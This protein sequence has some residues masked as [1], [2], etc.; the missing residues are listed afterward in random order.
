MILIAYGNENGNAF[1][2]GKD[3]TK[4]LD[5]HGAAVSSIDFS[6]NGDLVATGSWDGIARLWRS[7]VNNEPVEF[8]LHDSWIRDV[9][10]SSNSQFLL[11]GGKDRLV[12]R[13]SMQEVK[14]METLLAMKYE[15]F[16]QPE[17]KLHV[18]DDIDQPS[19]YD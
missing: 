1:L 19:L 4:T 8:A 15:A 17:W 2:I 18:G 16:T 3:Q 9:R 13:Y 10:F 6:S 11:S 12:F 7:E 5:G 14:I